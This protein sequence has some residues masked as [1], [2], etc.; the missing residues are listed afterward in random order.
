[1]ITTATRR[2]ASTLS[3][4]PMFPSSIDMAPRDIVGQ[5]P[6]CDG[7]RGTHV[8][9]ASRAAVEA[10]MYVRQLL[11]VIDEPRLPDFPAS[12]RF[13]WSAALREER[14]AQPF[15]AR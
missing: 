15:R 2:A 11:W 3:Q 8:I 6:D 10:E 12:R 14:S 9:F 13:G 4:I 7:L 5:L 1:M